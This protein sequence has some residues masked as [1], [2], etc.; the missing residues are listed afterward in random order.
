VLTVILVGIAVSV[1][2]TMFRDQT[3]QSSK[4]AITA[5]LVTLAARAYQY[6]I[7]PATMGGG[8]GKYLAALKLADIASNEMINNA[9]GSYALTVDN[10]DQVTIVGTGKVGTSPWV[11]TCVVNATGTT[12]FSS[13]GGTY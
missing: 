3:L 12:S 9:N 4:D 6:R 7:K 5:D 11:V 10:D 8:G 2:V 1:G 13:T